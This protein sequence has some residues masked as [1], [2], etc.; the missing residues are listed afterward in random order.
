MNKGIFIGLGGSGVKSVARIKYKIL[1]RLYHNNP[2]AIE[3]DFAF[4]F[5]DTDNGDINRLNNNYRSSLGNKDLIED[6]EIVRL[7][8]TNPFQ[9]YW[10]CKNANQKNAQQNRLLEWMDPKAANAL[11]D[12]PLVHGAGGI[13]VEGRTAIWSN[14]RIIRPKINRA[15]NIIREIKT[16]AELEKA[17]PQFWVFSGSC[18]GTGSS[19][20]LDFLYIFDREF[21]ER[22]TNLGD[23]Y[24]RVVLF[25]PNGFVE[26]FDQSIQRQKYMPNAYALFKEIEMFLEDRW[27]KEEVQESNFRHFS[28][29]PDPGDPKKP[30]PIFQYGILCDVLTEN[31]FHMSLE[32]LY[33]SV[34]EMIYYIH[35]GAVQ[36]TMLSDFD[37]QILDTIKQRNGGWKAFIGMGYRALRNAFSDF[38][39]TYIRSRLE[40]ELF[41]YGLLGKSMNE[42]ISDKSDQQK[43][44]GEAFKK[45]ILQPL[46]LSDL[47]SDESNLKAYVE[48]QIYPLFPFTDQDFRKKKDKHDTNKISDINRLEYFQQQAFD[49]AASLVNSVK[50]DF[51]GL[52]SPFSRDE[53]KKRIETSLKIQ[54]ESMMLIYGLIFS[55]EFFYRLDLLCENFIN[56]LQQKIAIGNQKIQQLESELDHL[57]QMC[58]KNG[59]KTFPVFYQKLKEYIDLHLELQI[60]RERLD[61]LKWFSVGETGLIDEYERITGALKEKLESLA[62]KNEKNYKIYLAKK[63]Q[64]TYRNPT[65]SFIPRIHEFVSTEGWKSDHLFAKLYEQQIPVLPYGGEPMRHAQDPDRSREGLQKILYTLFTNPQVFRGEVEISPYYDQKLGSIRFFSRILDGSWNIGQ[66]LNELLNLINGYV[67]NILITPGSPIGREI[68][69]NIWDIYKI[70]VASQESE[71][72]RIQNEFSEEGTQ[73]FCPL[74]FAAGGKPA[75]KFYFVAPSQSLANELG[76]QENDPNHQF[77]VD[78]Q[79][80]AVYKIKFYLGITFENYGPYKYYKDAYQYLKENSPKRFYPHIHRI[81]NQADT[82]QDALEMLSKRFQAEDLQFF[83]KLL[84]YNKIGEILQKEE[85]EKQRNSVFHVTDNIGDNA[86]VFT[87]VKVQS[88]ADH[89]VIKMIKHESIPIHK[90]KIN[91]VE[92]DL[93]KVYSGDNDL[94]SCFDTLR[95]DFQRYRNRIADFEDKLKGR[96]RQNWLEVFNG[97][98]ESLREEFKFFHEQIQGVEFYADL[99]KFTNL[100]KEMLIKMIQ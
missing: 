56:D 28:A 20:L 12:Q 64:D 7:G 69:R 78:Q 84:F 83:L 90:R 24:L 44:M 88:L 16:R 87:P 93:E 70:Y 58:R 77:L 17:R 50:N 5:L 68:H 42:E 37:N 47:P 31:E 25:M 34:A 23:P 40:F 10:L 76:Y 80:N 89:L 51:E 29:V 66:L 91:I 79:L 14:Y 41:K 73:V 3:E 53:I 30:W 86:S 54:F 8:D 43:M 48:E 2:Q 57:K 100:V 74:N 59:K 26:L 61:I 22:Y 96:I 63:F 52:S 71:L 65:T 6:V 72:R 32:E 18:G 92:G 38:L 46:G 60:D 99:H 49:L 9:S 85:F 45:I 35:L 81:F 36:E 67:Q 19:A 27:G 55:K 1:T 62:N 4:L 11:R 98:A 75:P 21:R 94:V 39:P 15:L 95:S 33:E 13:R 97:V 82:L